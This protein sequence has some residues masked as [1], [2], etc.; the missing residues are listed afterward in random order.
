MAC[1]LCDCRGLRVE[2]YL[3]RSLEEVLAYRRHRQLGVGP[4]PPEVARAVQ[5]EEALH[6]PEALLHPETDLHTVAGRTRRGNP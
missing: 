1:G 5:A 3:V 2:D 6:G 4:G